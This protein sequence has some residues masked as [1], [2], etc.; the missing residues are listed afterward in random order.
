M[1]LVVAAFGSTETKRYQFDCEPGE[2]EAQ[3][4]LDVRLVAAAQALME[5]DGF[6]AAEVS[7]ANF[8]VEYP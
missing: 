1:P 4:E 2:D 7:T 6:T 3:N 8:R 5:M